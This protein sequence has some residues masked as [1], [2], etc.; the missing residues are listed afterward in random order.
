MRRR[1]ASFICYVIG[2]CAKSTAIPRLSA[3][4]C[5]MIQ[6]ILESGSELPEIYL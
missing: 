4:V 5:E 2:G 6:R 1:L 3:A